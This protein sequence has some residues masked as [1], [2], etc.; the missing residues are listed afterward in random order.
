MENAPY[1]SNDVLHEVGIEPEAISDVAAFLEIPA[2]QTVSQANLLFLQIT[3]HQ[4][5]CY[6]DTKWMKI[7][8]V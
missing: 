1:S 5:F 2:F 3:Q 8:F 7:P 6:S 4:A